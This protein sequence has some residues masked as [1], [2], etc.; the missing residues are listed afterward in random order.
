LFIRAFN[1]TE[2]AA[3]IK[4][5]FLDID[6]TLL[7]FDAFVKAAMRDC[8]K[9]LSGTDANFQDASSD[10]FNSLLDT[11]ISAVSMGVQAL[12]VIY[13]ISDIRAASPTPM[14]ELAQDAGTAEEDDLP[15]VEE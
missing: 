6:N 7:D 12:N 3:M 11:C 9:A 13:R 8:L 5:V 1:E 14:E 4:A 15:D 10:L 2:A